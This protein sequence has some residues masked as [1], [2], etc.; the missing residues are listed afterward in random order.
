MNKFIPSG[1]R[2]EIVGVGRGS[3]GG[4]SWAARVG[5]VPAVVC[6][7]VPTGRRWW[8][9]GEAGRGE[10]GAVVVGAWVVGVG[11][12]GGCGNG[13]GEAGRWRARRW[14][15]AGRRDGSG[16]GR[17]EACRRRRVRPDGEA[18]AVSVVSESEREGEAADGKVSL[19]CRVPAIRHSAK[20]FLKF[21]NILLPSVRDPT[22]GKVLFAECRPGDTRQRLFPYTLPSATQF[23]LGKEFF[24]ECLLWALGKVHF[25]FFYFPNQTFCG[26][27]LHYVDLHIPFL[28]QLKK[29]FL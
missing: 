17:G 28:G 29:C 4:G 2:R 26:M 24:A 12:R 1:D 15:G 13:R 21:K 16:N 6:V 19:L 10:A 27:F 20:I 8:P 23:T 11:R 5:V 22:L 9:D 3:R 25:Y 14:P 18:A 7:A